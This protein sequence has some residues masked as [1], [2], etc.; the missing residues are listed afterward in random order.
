MHPARHG[1]Q[2]QSLADAV[3]APGKRTLLHKHSLSEEIYYILAGCGEVR[4]GDKCYPVKV[5]DSI[6]IPP[7]IPHN[8]KN[9][10]NE[11]LI[12]LCCCSPAYSHDD[13]RLLD[14]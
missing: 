1:C 11:A 6:C 10:G 2:N 3:V 13:T 9:T 12:F 14:E 7:G 8:I 5:G 4:L